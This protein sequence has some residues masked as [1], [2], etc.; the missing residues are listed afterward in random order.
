MLVAALL[1]S[2]GRRV[3]P[4][5]TWTRKPCWQVGIDEKKLKEGITPLRKASGGPG[6]VVVRHGYLVYSAGRYT[7]PGKVFSMSKSLT[8]LIFGYLQA[9]GKVCLDDRVELSSDPRAHPATFRNYLNMTSNYGLEPPVAGKFF[10]YNNGAFNVLGDYMRDRF[11]PGETSGSVLQ[12]VLW[13]HIGHEDPISMDQLWSGWNG[14][15]R[16]SAR[17]LARVGVL[18]LN[19]GKVKGRTLIAEDFVASLFEPQIPGEAEPCERTDPASFFNQPFFTHRMK[20]R[21]SFG[22]W[23]GEPNRKLGRYISMRGRQRSFLIVV[24]RLDLVIAV[25]NDNKGRRNYASDRDY[26][27]AVERSVRW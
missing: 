20:G 8:S 12:T 6:L 2:C 19:R 16:V 10:A 21:Y 25:T 4:G 24:P 14:G 1:C 18:L 23:I 17:D 15:S 26:L 5:P 9:A 27:E 22:W 11:F 13:D 7:E 3:E